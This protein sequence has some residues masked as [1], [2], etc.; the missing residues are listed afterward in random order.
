[1]RRERKKERAEWR[2]RERM[3]EESLIC[4][5]LCKDTDLFVDRELSTSGEGKIVTEKKEKEKSKEE[6]K[7]VR[8]K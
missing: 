7:T 2:E 3:N 1:M 5:I 6:T 4:K 8:D